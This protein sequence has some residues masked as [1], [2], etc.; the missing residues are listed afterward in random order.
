MTEPEAPAVPL[1]EAPPPPT[2]EPPRRRRRV[3]FILLGLCVAWLAWEALTWPD[4]AALAKNQ[5]ETTAF[6]ERY[7]RGPWMGLGPDRKVEWKWVPGSRISSNLKRAVIVSED[8]EFFSHNGFSTREQRAALEDA[9]EDKKLPRGASTISQQLAKNLWLSPSYNPLRKAK[10]ALFTWQLER[11]LSKRRILEVYLNVVEFGEGI[12][13]AEAAAR[14]YYGRSAAGL[15]E[16]QA[17]ELAASLP[18]PKSWHPGST[19]K[20]YQRKIRSIQR[21]MA[22]AGWL[23]RRV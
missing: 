18:R 10:E 5:P 7:R 1:E 20:S 15:S 4:M 19:S 6:I 16:R 14:H 22:K 3:L 11:T 9:W 21:R 23:R 13:G 8:I 17:A 2:P 12:Y